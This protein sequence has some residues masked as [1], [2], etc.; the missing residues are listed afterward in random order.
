VFVRL[1][2]KT[3]NNKGELKLLSEVKPAHAAHERYI[4]LFPYD[5]SIQ[6][7]WVKNNNS[8]KGFSG[9]QYCRRI[10]IDI[11]NENLD[12]AL[13]STLKLL[14]RFNNNYSLSSNDIR[15]YFSGSKGFHISISESVLG[16]ILPQSNI[17]KVVGEFVKQITFGITNIDLSIYDN[18]RVIRVSNS[19]NAKSNLYKIPLEYSDLEDGMDAIKELAEQPR[20]LPQNNTK[21]SVNNTLKD[22]FLSINVANDDMSNG[23]EVSDG[24]FSPQGI[25]NRNNQL[26]KQ[27]CVLFRSS[28]LKVKSVV[29]ILSSIN[30]A[31]DKPISDAELLLVVSSAEKSVGIKDI[32]E[33]LV[34]KPFGGWVDDWY[35]SILPEQNK[36]SL[37]FPSFDGVLKHKL[38]GKVA[39][40]MGKG[41]TKKSLYAQN[42]AF[43]NIFN[44][45]ARIIY[46]TM[47]MGANELNSRFIDMSN[48]KPSKNTSVELEEKEL[49]DEGYAKKYVKENITPMYNDKLLITQN[50]GLQT[51]HYDTLIEKA[52]IEW[53]EVDML[54]PDGLSMMGGK[55]EETELVNRHTKELKQ[56]AIKH[57]IFIPLIVHVTK[58]SEKTTRD[59]SKYARGSEKIVDNCDFHIS[60]SLCL[61]DFSTM[62][63]DEVGIEDEFRRDIGYIRLVDKRG[64]G[65]VVSKIYHFDDR[66]L[67]MEESDIRPI[68]F[69]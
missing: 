59:V 49:E 6:T 44:H 68:N 64:S 9:L 15:I 14:D 1:I 34:L 32:D 66:N 19:L 50:T 7:Y 10:I 51:K 38:R 25:G 27:A 58:S 56:L 37:I 20:T 41:G 12:K 42:L 52:K 46:S 63:G 40:I 39:I 24:F 33:D 28:D 13:D 31:S 47:E 61:K 3:L 17:A 65:E 5:K 4:S 23:F 48:A 16:G 29:E 53:G 69:N 30:R 35:Q 55:G 22:I 18:Q 67:L 62:L 2:E 36:L 11:D 43:Y 57:N 45:G 21:I 8:A 26:F 60:M 54:I